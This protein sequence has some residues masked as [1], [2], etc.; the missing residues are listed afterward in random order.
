VLERS[1]YQDRRESVFMVGD[2]KFDMIGAKECRIGSI[3]AAY[4]YGDR[5]ELV[6]AGA[7]LIFDSVKEL[8]DFLVTL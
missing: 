7:D 5:D 3:G 1:G 6:H 2:R 8:K 4:G